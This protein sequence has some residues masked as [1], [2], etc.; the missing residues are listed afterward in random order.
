MCDTDLTL[1]YNDSVVLPLHVKEETNDL[2]YV[3]LGGL[4]LHIHDCNNWETTAIIK[5]CSSCH[6][7]LVEEKLPIYSIPNLFFPERIPE[8]IARLSIAETLLISKVFHRS[9]VWESQHSHSRLNHHVVC[10]D[11]TYN[12]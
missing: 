3:E 1:D 6:S 10:F 5:L 12:R 2:P 8:V 4:K 7:D 9:I 11:A